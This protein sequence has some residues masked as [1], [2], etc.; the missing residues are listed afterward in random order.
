[1]PPAIIPPAIIPGIAGAPGG[2]AMPGIPPGGAPIMPG[3]CSGE[4]EGGGV[5]VGEASV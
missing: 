5:G 2:A 4:R 1:M 3:I